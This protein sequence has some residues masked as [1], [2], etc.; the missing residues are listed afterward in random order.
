MTNICRFTVP[1]SQDLEKILDYIA[2]VNS[3]DTAENFLA[4]IN[5]KCQRLTSFPNM[6]KKREELLP[7]L[8][9]LPVDSYLIFY[10]PIPEGIE[11]LRIVSG[12]QD[13]KA[14]FEEEE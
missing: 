5:K 6:G 3:V 9:S 8:R 11:I 10:R 2:E 4:R 7:F 13:L 1:A 12:Y 14:L